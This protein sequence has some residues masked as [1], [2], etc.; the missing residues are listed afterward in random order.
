MYKS[1]HFLRIDFIYSISKN[2]RIVRYSKQFLISTRECF[3][4]LIDNIKII[5]RNL[6]LKQTYLKIVQVFTSNFNN[7]LSKGLHSYIQIKNF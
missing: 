4:G 1:L 5:W 6:T 2:R 3:K 7:L